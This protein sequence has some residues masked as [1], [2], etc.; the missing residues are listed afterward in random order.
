MAD[1][2]NLV[3]PLGRLVRGSLNERAK[4]DYDGNPYPPG[5]GPFELGFAIRKDDP[6]TGEFLGK[7]YQKA[8]SDAPNLKTRIDGEWQSGFTMGS[9]RFKVRDGDRPNQKGA[10]NQN[11]VGHYVL[12]LSTN[13]AVKF[14]YTD[15]FGLRLTDVMGQP[16]LPRTAIPPEK[17]KI[18]DYAFLSI[19]AK[20]N[21]KMDATAGIFLSQ[22]A[23]MLAGYGEA[24][25]GGLSLDE[26]FASVPTGQLPAGASVAA[27]ASLPGIATPQQQ[28]AQHLAASVAGPAAAYAAPGLPTPN[29]APAAAIGGMPLP[30]AAPGGQP[31]LPTAAP[32]NLPPPHNGFVQAAVGLP[33]QVPF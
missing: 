1:Y 15:Q 33:D 26:A 9:F 10:V 3:T 2:L 29:A 5:E 16:I 7:L 12:N 19:S 28:V 23:V 17:I 31:T 11:T 30:G 14:T 27:P 25:S 20:Y 32:G 6:A 18:G 22:A 8:I 24:I 21:D 4:E 13:L